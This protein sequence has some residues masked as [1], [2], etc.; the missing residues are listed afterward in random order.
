MSLR[1]KFFFA[2][3]AGTLSLGSPAVVMAEVG[4]GFGFVSPGSKGQVNYGGKI[5]ESAPTSAVPRKAPV[6]VRNPAKASEPKPCGSGLFYSD[7]ACVF[8]DDANVPTPRPLMPAAPAPVAAGEPQPEVITAIEYFRTHHLPVPAPVVSAPEGITG[9]V[10]SLDLRMPATEMY[11]DNSTPLGPV[12]LNATG[13]FTVDWGDGTSDTY[14]VTGAPYPDSL[15]THTWRDRGTYDIAVTAQWS[16]DWS[17]AGQTGT[18][19]GLT[20]TGAIPAFTVYELQ[21]VVTVN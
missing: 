3:A 16:I 17:Y 10:H 14:T 1:S 20:T 7:G 12:V 8:L 5:Q 2:V 15:L 9:A 18:V 4:R 19:T 6:R 21:A 13:R 11:T